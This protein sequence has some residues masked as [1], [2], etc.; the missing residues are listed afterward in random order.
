MKNIQQKL[1]KRNTY[2]PTDASQ[3]CSSVNL[4]LNKEETLSE[5]ILKTLPNN[6]E[7]NLHQNRTGGY[8]TKVFVQNKNN[9][10]H[11]ELEKTFLVNHGEVL[12][13]TNIEVEV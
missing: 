8:K 10:S 3:V 11:D 12:L 9:I 7:V 1:G 6:L 5:Q 13:F 4:S 2:T